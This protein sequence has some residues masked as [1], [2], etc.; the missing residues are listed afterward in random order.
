MPIGRSLHI[1]INEF[2]PVFPNATVLTGAENAAREMERLAQSRGFRA[3]RLLGPNASY[4]AVIAKLL[5]AA[6]DSNDGDIFLFTFCGHGTFDTDRDGDEDDYQDEALLLY[7]ALLFDD[8]LKLKIWPNF[9]RG[10]RVL[11]VADSCHSGTVVRFLKS[12]ET[13]RAQILQISEETRQRH[14]REYREFYQSVVVPIRATI[15]ASVLLL[16]ACRDEE[17]TIDG[18]PLTMFTGA[19]LKVVNEQNPQNYRDL[20]QKIDALV[21]PQTPVLTPLPPPNQAFINQIPFTI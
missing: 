14:L 17:T 10:V 18:D 21:G 19:L 7:D 2:S 15:E 4:A 20:I 11:M 12:G 1:G 16:A 5:K 13:N 9:R 8:E 3:E 6:D